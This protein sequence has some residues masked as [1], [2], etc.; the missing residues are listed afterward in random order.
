MSD[1]K[2]PHHDE[3]AMGTTEWVAPEH[4]EQHRG[5]TPAVLVGA[6]AGLAAM[7]L[8]WATTAILSGNDNGRA[9]TSTVTTGAE[10]SQQAQASSRPNRM[11]RCEQADAELAGLLR[12]AVPALDQWEIH[13]GAMNKLVVGAITLQQAT[14][15]WEQTRLGAER[16]LDHF[17]SATRQIPFAGAG[18]PSPGALAQAPTRLRS[19]AQ[20]VAGERAAVEAARIAMQTWQ[21]HVG[22][23]EMLRLGQMSPAAATR[24]WLA[25]WHQGV[26][27]FQA[28]RG[29]DRAVSSS[30]GC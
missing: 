2:D 27:E 11:L 9:P 1:P 28:Y 20:H 8:V 7:G 21:T 22:H 12:A 3:W 29:A 30:G 13:V 23:M 16:R 24:M 14:A 6:L 15:F 17:H 4:R 26:R 5:K 18:C 10:P 25:S 19:C